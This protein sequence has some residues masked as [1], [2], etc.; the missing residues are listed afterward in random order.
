MIS[1]SACG[2]FKGGGLTE[3]ERESGREWLSKKNPL[4]VMLAVKLATGSTEHFSKTMLTESIANKLDPIDW[5]KEVNS[6]SI[7]GDFITVAEQLYCLPASSASIERSYS[8]L[9][10]IITKKRNRISVEKAEKL[11]GIFQNSK[12]VQDA[13]EYV[14]LKR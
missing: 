5:W 9:G 7:H 2:V 8:V 4:F 6:S 3:T 1:L 10:N 12:A 13:Q 11:C 14:D